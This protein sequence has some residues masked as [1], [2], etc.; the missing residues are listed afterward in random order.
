MTHI[1]AIESIYKRF[2]ELGIIKE[3][4]PSD[5]CPLSRQKNLRDRKYFRKKR[6]YSGSGKIF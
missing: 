6:R 5:I 4:E 3:E 2:E 1:E